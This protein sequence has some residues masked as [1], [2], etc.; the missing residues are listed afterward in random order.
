MDNRIALSSALASATGFLLI[1]F[2][3]TAERLPDSPH[4][5]RPLFTRLNGSAEVPGPGDSNGEGIA[6]LTL[7]HGQGEICYS[8]KV[9]NMG[10]AT[11]AHIHRGAVG[12]AG[13]VV[14]P[15]MA[16]GTNGVAQGCVTVDRSLVKEIMQQ[17]GA[18][19]V[20]VHTTN[21]PNGAIRGQLSKS[22]GMVPV[23]TTNAPP[24]NASPATAEISTTLRADFAIEASR[25]GN[26]LIISWTPSGGTLQVSAALKG[27]STVWTDV[28]ST[29]PALIPAGTGSAFYRVKNP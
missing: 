24:T 13:P 4:G 20:N 3:V 2:S 10:P 17:P 14:V 28:G 7:N 6:L 19:Y 22:P 23:M 29:N 9:S 11:A 8:L 12:V 25:S 26:Q 18:F 1:L 5:G 15:L 27:A 16:P 21:F